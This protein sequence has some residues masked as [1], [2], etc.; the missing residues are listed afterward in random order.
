MYNIKTCLVVNEVTGG[1]SDIE[2]KPDGAVLL[3]ALHNLSDALH[4]FS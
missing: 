2:L 1:E 3:M 4:L